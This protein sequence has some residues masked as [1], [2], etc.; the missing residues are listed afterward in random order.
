MSSDGPRQRR[1]FL[2]EY[3]LMARELCRLARAPDM[4]IESNP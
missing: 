2:S 1:A 3:L 4:Q